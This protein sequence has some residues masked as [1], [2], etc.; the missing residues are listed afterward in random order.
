M[1]NSKSIQYFYKLK[2]FI[3]SVLEWALSDSISLIIN[4]IFIISQISPKVN[5]IFIQAQKFN[6][7]CFRMDTVWP[8][9]FVWGFL[10]T[11]STPQ[12]VRPRK[13]AK[14]T[15]SCSSAASTSSKTRFESSLKNTYFYF[16]YCLNYNA[17]WKL[18]KKYLFLFFY[19]LN[20]NAG[21]KLSWLQMVTSFFGDFENLK[22]E[23]VRGQIF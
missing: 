7:I 16:F 4:I 1:S 10:T 3:E 18:F 6:L 9:L 5:P 17:V 22:I 20:F 8:R 21:Q 11:R 23:A 13:T 14:A 15:T 19:C 2:I 12:N